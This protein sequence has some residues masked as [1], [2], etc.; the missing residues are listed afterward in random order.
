MGVTNCCVWQLS[1]VT[2]LL[3]GADTLTTLLLTRFVQLYCKYQDSRT[4]QVTVNRRGFSRSSGSGS[5]DVGGN[6][7][8]ISGVVG[9]NGG[10]GSGGGG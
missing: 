5:S 8:F 7:W 9:C 6:G 2:H 4:C 10:V 3:A 1:K